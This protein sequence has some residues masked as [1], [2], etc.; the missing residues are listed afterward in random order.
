[1]FDSEY[2]RTALQSDVDALGGT[3]VVAVLL[4]SGRVHRVRAV[5]AIHNGY[6]T[7]EAF[8]ARAD[9]PTREPRW[10]ESPGAGAAT[11]ETHWAVVAYE[12]IAD[13]TITASRPDGAGIGFA[14]P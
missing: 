4:S 2:F 13:V 8:Q 10:K 9:A 3:A 5:L 7:L 11:Y 6:V 12:H 1:M 14:R